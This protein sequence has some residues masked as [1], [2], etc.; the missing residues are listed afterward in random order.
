MKK[1]KNN[2]INRPNHGT[3]WQKV[4][5]IPKS[6]GKNKSKKK[7]TW[8]KKFKNSYINLGIIEK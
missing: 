6:A 1:I 7:Q 3:K 8:T 2:S 5:K 4:A